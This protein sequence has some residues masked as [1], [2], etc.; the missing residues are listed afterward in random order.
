MRTH[1]VL[2]KTILI[3]SLTASALIAASSVGAQT[4]V[5]KL[6]DSLGNVTYTDVAPKKPDKATVVETITFVDTHS[7]TDHA[8]VAPVLTYPPIT[9]ADEDVH[10]YD[11]I[12]IVSPGNDETLRANNGDIVLRAALAPPLRPGHALRF[13]LGNEP[14]GTVSSV[15][16]ALANV[17]RGTHDL[18]VDVLDENREVLESSTSSTFHLQRTSALAPTRKPRSTPPALKR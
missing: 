4:V 15:E 14:V 8:S 18:R 16:L 10:K 7:G 17:D 6:T 9:W 3:W 13:Y 1:P 11:N 12:A 5:Y 2:G